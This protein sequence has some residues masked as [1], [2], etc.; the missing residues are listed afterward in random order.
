M[1]ISFF[2]FS[3]LKEA[4]LKKHVQDPGETGVASCIHGEMEGPFPDQ[5]MQFH[6]FSLYPHSL[7]GLAEKVLIL[8]ILIK[9]C[10]LKSP[11]PLF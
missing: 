2:F 11:V 9:I 4:A 8:I 10:A 7:V 3:K 1:L 6:P 5:Q